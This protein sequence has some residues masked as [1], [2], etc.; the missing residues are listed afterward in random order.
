MQ[1][2]INTVK[3]TALGVAEYLTPVLKDSKFK[4][5]GVLTPEEFVK[6]GDHLVHHCP[7]WQWA[8]GDE[9][10][11]KP[12]LPKNKQFLLTRNV[13]CYKRCKQLEY[14]DQEKIVQ[15]ED[16]EGG[17]VDTHPTNENLT[18]GSATAEMSSEEKSDMEE[19]EDM[20]NNLG[21]AIADLALADDDDDGE[22]AVME[23]SD[24]EDEEDEA[25]VKPTFDRE[26]VKPKF[27]EPSGEI[28]QTRTY[29]LNITY[30][31]YYQT[32]RLWVSGHDE[33]S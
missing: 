22:A 27:S 1:N 15:P 2:V 7:T 3:G 6:A 18:E 5:T 4:E 25:E 28:I 17:W 12:Y 31:K 21:N 24:L 14:T 11:I 29:D 32:P 23:D 16:G 19:A 26:N 10:K 20:Q 9:S 13:P 8:T 30:D 33:V